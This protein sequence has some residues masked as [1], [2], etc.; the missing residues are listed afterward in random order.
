[1]IDWLIDIFLIKILYTCSVVHIT[2]TFWLLFGQLKLCQVPKGKSLEIAAENFLQPRCASWHLIVSNH[3]KNSLL[4]L[5]RVTAHAQYNTEMLFIK[6]TQ[7]HGKNLML[8]SGSVGWIKTL[9][10]GQWR[11]TVTYLT[12]HPLQTTQPITMHNNGTVMTQNKLTLR[13][14]GCNCQLDCLTVVLNITQ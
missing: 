11:L 8:T 12:R 9:H 6:Y 10:F 13:Q 4:T 3:W 7:E 1:M 2:I 14:T 5:Y